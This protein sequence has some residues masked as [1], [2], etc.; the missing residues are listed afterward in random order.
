MREIDK[1]IIHHSESNHKEHDNIDT[2]RSW[3]TDRGFNDVGYH[4][5]IRSDGRIERGRRVSVVGAHCFGYN[6]TSVGI[7]LHGDDIFTEEQ[8]ESL[9]I[10]IKFLRKILHK[11]ISIHGHCEFSSKSCPNFDYDRE[12]ISKL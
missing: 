10:L 6:Q 8:F 2:I 11:P 5:F 1:I 4:F 7:C 12:I 9:R 3:H